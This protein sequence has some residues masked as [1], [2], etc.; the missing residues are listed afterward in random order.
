VAAEEIELL[1]DSDVRTD[2][3]VTGT[4]LRPGPS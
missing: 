3:L 4:T 1:L 2:D